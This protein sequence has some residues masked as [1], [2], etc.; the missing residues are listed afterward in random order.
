M[1]AVRSPLIYRCQRLAHAGFVRCLSGCLQHAS[2]GTC[3]YDSSC[4]WCTGGRFTACLAASSSSDC[5]ATGG[6]WTNYYATCTFLTS[7]CAVLRVLSS[8]ACTVGPV[9]PAPADAC[10]AYSGG[11]NCVACVGASNNSTSSRQSCAWCQSS[12]TCGSAYSSA[13]QNSCGGINAVLDPTQFVQFAVLCTSLPAQPL[14]RFI[15]NCL[16]AVVGP[17]PPEISLTNILVASLGGFGVLIVAGVMWV[18]DRSG[19]SS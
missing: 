9:A 19:F 3:N 4:G 2:C 8:F 5:T 1:T 6:T 17:P 16:S 14:I 18:A 13:F 15:S 10:S 12:R 7:H 11:R